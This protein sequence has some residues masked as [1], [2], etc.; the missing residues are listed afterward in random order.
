[1][2]AAHRRR[3]QGHFAAAPKQYSPDAQIVLDGAAGRI[4]H[5]R[6]ED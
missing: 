4:S 6:L 5:R 1:M 3:R 2:Q